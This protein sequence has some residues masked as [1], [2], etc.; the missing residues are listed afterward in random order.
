MNPAAIAADQPT[1]RKVAIV[2]GGPTRV[3]APFNDPTWEIWAF[4][5][6]R[7]QPPRV[8]RW[9]ELH[10]LT[11]LRQ[12]LA[13]RKPGRRTFPE[14]WRYLSSLPCPVYMQRRHRAIPTS[15]P[16]PLGPVLKRFGRC[17]TSTASY[18]VALAILEGAQV[19]G[20]WGVNPKRSDKGHRDEDYSRQRAALEYLLGVARQRGIEVVLPPGVSLRVP[21][22]PRF[23]ATPVLYA[24]DWRSPHAWWRDRVREQWRLQRALA[25]SATH[26]HRNQEHRSRAVPSRALSSRAAPSQTMPYRAIPPRTLPLRSVR[27]RARA[28]RVN[29]AGPQP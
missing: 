19:I 3:M 11:D 20:L 1:P 8:T 23:V 18:L 28:T 15:V 29:G 16:F 22:R 9:F 6:R 12:Q 13:S 2:G 17:F 24:Y 14:Y 21:E 10:A 25:Q 4:S 7:W 26:S 5:S 27:V